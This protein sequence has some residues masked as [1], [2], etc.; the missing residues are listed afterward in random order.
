M[1]TKIDQ[2][3]L[4]PEAIIERL[5]QGNERFARGEVA[6]R[7][8]ILEAKATAAEQY[9]LACIH[10]CIDS[11]VAPEIIFDLGIGEV[12]T[13]RIAGNAVGPEVLAGIEYACKLAGAKLL[14]VLAHTDCGA[15][16]AACDG[17]ELGHLTVLLEEIRPAVES[18]AESGK[19]TSANLSFVNRVAH[20]NLLFVL[21][22]IR[23]QSSLIHSME[24]QGEIRIAGAMYDLVKG[25]VTFL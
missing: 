14:L 9:P 23:R 3:M 16:K 7:S 5:K 19:R 6:K 10:T 20:Q 17:V 25:R 22:K 1:L 2:M 8:P 24:Q 18:T 12:F 21:E 13:T 4:T 15:I 11:R